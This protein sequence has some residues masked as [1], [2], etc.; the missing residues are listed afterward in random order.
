MVTTQL[1][2]QRHTLNEAWPILI[3]S[4]LIKPIIFSILP[5]RAF[6]TAGI[7]KSLPRGVSMKD[8]FKPLIVLS[9]LFFAGCGVTFVPY[10]YKKAEEAKFKTKNYNIKLHRKELQIIKDF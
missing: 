10:D 4:M 5:K 7:V 2:L 6:G 9:V 8:P 3:D 1:A